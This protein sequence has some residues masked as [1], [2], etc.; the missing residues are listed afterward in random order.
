MQVQRC[1][2]MLWVRHHAAPPLP[3]GRSAIIL[4]HPCPVCNTCNNFVPVQ[5]FL[6]KFRDQAEAQI[7]AT[8]RDLAAAEGSFAQVGGCVILLQCPAPAPPVQP[9]FSPPLRSIATPLPS[10]PRW[11]PTS[12]GPA[13]SLRPPPS[14]SSSRPL[15]AASR[16][17]TTT[18]RSP[19]QRWWR[20]RGREGP[21]RPGIA[22][23]S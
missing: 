13:T 16:R 2:P 14:S 4:R 6:A 1:A 15:L 21:C 17:R 3:L 23:A 19:T 18:T 10:S 12:T 7:A 20:G 5:A 9:F 22:A 11:P 8:E